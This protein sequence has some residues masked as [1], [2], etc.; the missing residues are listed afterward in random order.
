MQ[1]EK[2]MGY[3]IDITMPVRYGRENQDTMSTYWNRHVKCA[4]SD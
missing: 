3:R 1:G 4:C 2:K